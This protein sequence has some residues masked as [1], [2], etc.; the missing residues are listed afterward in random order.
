VTRAR[1]ASLAASVRQAI[2]AHARAEAPKE[3]CGLLIGAGRR[4]DFAVP[5]SN[6]DPRP[7]SGF[8]VDPAEHI[9]VRRIVRRVTPA[10]AVV[11]VYHSHPRGPAVPSSR[12]I[13]ECHYPDW[14][15]VI[16][17]R[18]GRSIR[19]YQ[20]RSAGPAMVPIVWRKL[21]RQGRPR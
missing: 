19:G 7:T 20:L 18:G 13:A 17:G 4:V 21:P 15:F 6:L 5:L 8:R 2:V 9:A 1:P 11:G 12:D 10:R 3:C 14:I 16:V